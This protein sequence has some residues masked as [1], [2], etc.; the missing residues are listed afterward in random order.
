M[1]LSQTTLLPF[2][3]AALC[4]RS[5]GAESAL[6]AANDAGPSSNRQELSATYVS[7]LDQNLTIRH[8]AVLPV[9]DNVEGIYARPIEA[10]LIQLVKAS[11]RWDFVETSI[12]SS[13]QV[14][15]LL[16]LEENPTEVQKLLHSVEAEAAVMAAATR[17]PNG[18]SIRV[19]LFLKK[20]GKLLSQEIL[21]DHP[22]NELAEIKDRVSDLYRRAVSRIPYDGLV[23]SRELNRVT[24]NLGKSDG[25]GKDQII[26]AVQ[27][28]GLTRHPKFNFIVSSEK[29]ILGRIKIL[30]VDETL[31]FG[32]IISEKERGAIQKF[33][34]VSGLEQVNY[35]EPASMKDSGAPGDINSRSDAPVSFGKDPT[36]WVPVRPP[37]FGEVG[38]ALGLGN[39]DT[40]VNTSSGTYEASTSIYPS[41]SLHGEMWLTKNWMA[42]T[43]ILQGVLSTSNPRSGST[44]GTLRQSVSRYSLEFGYNFLLRDEFFGPK[45]SISLGYSSYQMYVDS[46]TPTTFTSDTYS[47][48]QIGVGCLFPVTDDK[49]WYAGGRVNLIE[50]SNL[51][52]TPVSSGGSPQNQVIDFSVTVQKKIAENMRIVGGLDFSLF[53]T[54]FSGTGT[55]VGADGVT[56]EAASSL[57]QHHTVLSGGLNYMF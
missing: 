17:G 56:P 57:S 38:L 34:K 35:G 8:V 4:L 52:E 23:L 46:S 31:S 30:K 18:L 45:I 50:F 11:H 6:A 15:S 27:I 37:S 47:G 5:L 13:L 33:A 43:D 2:F 9:V 14:P 25:L 39:Y 3:L 20:D 24:I 7:E 10:Q 19:D 55:R 28:L 16:E 48:P 41:V 54:T 1:S 53:S 49:V 29:E 36:E 51:S 44:P 21:R 42:R 26:T 32:A 12:D 40:S 22:R